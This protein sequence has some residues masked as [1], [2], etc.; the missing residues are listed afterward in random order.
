MTRTC[1][2]IRWRVASHG[3]RLPRGQVCDVVPQRDPAR[4]RI[5]PSVAGTVGAL[6]G[7]PR[8]RVALRVER[9]VVL[10]AVGPTKL[11]VVG[12]LPVP[13]TPATN[14]YRPLPRAAGR[15]M[16]WRAASAP[17]GPC[18]WCGG[19]ASITPSHAGRLD[20]R[21]PGSLT[22]GRLRRGKL[23][24]ELLDG[25]DGSSSTGADRQRSQRPRGQ[26]LVELRPSDRAGLGG[27]LRSQQTASPLGPPCV[28]YVPVYTDARRT[29]A[30]R[31][32]RHS[33]HLVH[34][35]KTGS[36]S[37]PR[38]LALHVELELRQRVDVRGCLSQDVADEL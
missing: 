28:R 22:A 29:V 26:E 16:R 12:S 25:R 24:D 10:R 23:L 21:I 37:R 35:L 34:A 4:G 27:L 19:E 38:Q 13:E 31:N 1:Q 33:L 32:G 17:S 6:L 30:R 9:L 20:I 14:G 18:V 36:G 15:A 5:D 2:T 11:H 7:L 8:L 3:R